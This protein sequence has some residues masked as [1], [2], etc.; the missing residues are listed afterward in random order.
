MAMLPFVAPVEAGIWD[1][2]SG[3][4]SK[5]KNAPP[6]IKP[7]LVQDKVGVVLEVK[8]KYKIIDPHT[9]KHIGTRFDGKRKFI[10][11]CFQD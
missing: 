1:T 7:L 11:Y 9:G 3:Y 10:R 5:T 2:I 8:G 4:F 6:T